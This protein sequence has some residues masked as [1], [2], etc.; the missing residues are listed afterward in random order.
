MLLTV[1]LEFTGMNLHERDSSYRIPP[2]TMDCLVGGKPYGLPFIL[3]TLSKYDL[4]AT[5]FVEPLA[6]FYFGPEAMAVN[7]SRIHDHGQDIQLHMHPSWLVFE[8]GRPHSDRLCEYT[9]DEQTRMLA[10]GLKILREHGASPTA[11]R[12]GN[13]AANNDTYRAMANNG[14]RLASNFNYAYLKSICFVDSPEAANDIFRV[15]EA[16]EIPMTNYLIRDPRR[17]LRYAPKPFQ[18]SCTS[19]HHTRF[20]LDYAARN[21]YQY[22]TV[23][24]HNFEFLDRRHPDWMNRPFRK[25]DRLVHNF[26]ALCGHLAANRDRYSTTTFAAVGRD[27]TDGKALKGSSIGPEAGYPKLPGFYLPL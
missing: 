17:L 22:L 27:L 12:A 2:S 26:E 6:Q 4:E 19:W 1:D 23:L 16:V 18:I 13:F 10:L 14:L 21:E 5:F 9:L 15:G 11:L 8:D 25:N 3:D 7:I 20:M 24:L